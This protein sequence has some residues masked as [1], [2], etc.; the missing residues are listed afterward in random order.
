M[1]VIARFRVISRSQTLG[2]RH[3]DGAYVP[4]ELQTIE[5]NPVVSSDPNS[6]NGKF[7]AATPSGVIRL[8]VLNPE[9]GEY[10]LLNHE[11]D[12]LFTEVEAPAA[13]SV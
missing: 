7:F 1:S 6:P 5:L 3:V 13:P 12:V 8:A 11:Y 4:S 2:S 9:A 10:F